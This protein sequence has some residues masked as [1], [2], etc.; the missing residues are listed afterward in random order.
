MQPLLPFFIHSTFIPLSIFPSH[1]F[2]KKLH[3]PCICLVFLPTFLSPLSILPP[4]S[5]I[6]HPLPFDINN[7]PPQINHFFALIT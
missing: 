7:P 3:L 4:N 2:S 5:F 6:H 1:R